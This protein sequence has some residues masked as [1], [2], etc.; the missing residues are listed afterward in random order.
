MQI[1]FQSGVKVVVSLFLLLCGP[2]W[3]SS[4]SGGSGR[5][6]VQGSIVDSACAIAT[7]SREQE[8]EIG[9]FSIEEMIRNG[10]G[11]ARAFSIRLVN[12]VLERAGKPNWETFS[13]TFDGIR[14]RDNFSAAGT[15]SGISLR[16]SDA[17]GRIIIPGQAQ[18][19]KNIHPEKMALDYSITPVTNSEPLRPGNYSSIIKFRLDYF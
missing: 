2:A 19:R 1:A 4:S 3:A 16:I 13:I 11:P 8:I 18:P 6:S 7:D 9:G 15:A 17:D 5:V 10:H 14:D 12:C